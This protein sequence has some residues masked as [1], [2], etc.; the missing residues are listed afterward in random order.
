MAAQHYHVLRW[1]LCWSHAVDYGFRPEPSPSIAYA[2]HDH[3]AA[4]VHRRTQHQ[5]ALPIGQ[6][7]VGEMFASSVM[8]LA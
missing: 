7:A 3:Q 1:C 4:P 8:L 2:I 6:T 5:L